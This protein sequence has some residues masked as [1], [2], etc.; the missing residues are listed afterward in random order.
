MRPLSVSSLITSILFGFAHAAN[1][2]APPIPSQDPFYTQPANISLYSPGQ[3]IRSREV[4]N[5]YN[6]PGGQNITVGVESTSYQY[7]YRTTDSLEN[8]VAA[9]M[10]IFIPTN[11]T[12]GTKLLAYQVA[13]D[14]AS[15]DCAPSYGFRNGSTVSEGSDQV[16]VS[17]RNGSLI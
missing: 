14:S 10:T 12:D 3:V 4:T 9:A 1:T 11:N 6:G 7:L 15:G 8:P 5:S 13:E 16:M 17:H 2:T